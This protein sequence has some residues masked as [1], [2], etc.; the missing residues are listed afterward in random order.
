M[1]HPVASPERPTFIY[2]LSIYVLS[3]L[4]IIRI[5]R[6]LCRH[7]AEGYVSIVTPRGP[8]NAGKRHFVLAAMTHH[9][10]YIPVHT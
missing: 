4:W 3:F 10:L 7:Q 9:R 6:R 5:H 8:E 1:H 2:S